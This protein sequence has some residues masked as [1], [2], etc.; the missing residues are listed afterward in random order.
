MCDRTRKACPEN[1]AGTCCCHLEGSGTKLA[2]ASTAQSEV[3]FSLF[4]MGCLKG[5]MSRTTHLQKNWQVFSS[6]LIVIGLN[7][8][9]LRQLKPSLVIFAFLSFRWC[10]SMFENY[11]FKVSFNFKVIRKMT[12]TPWHF[13]FKNTTLSN[14]CRTDLF[15]FK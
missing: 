9:N 11:Y 15:S 13:S 3:M 12:K 7:V 1:Q 10:F 2:D 4:V 14:C 6:L 8:L 5:A